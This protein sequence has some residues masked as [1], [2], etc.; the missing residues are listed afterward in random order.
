MIRMSERVVAGVAATLAALVIA[1]ARA[2]AGSCGMGNQCA[3]VD[4]VSLAPDGAGAVT[5]TCSAHD[6]DG[7]VTRVTLSATGGA[8]AGGATTVDVTP[9]ASAQSVTLTATWSGAPGATVSCAA[10]DSGGLMGVPTR[11]AGASALWAPPVNPPVIDTLAGELTDPLVGQ[12]VQLLGAAHDPGGQALTATWSSTGGSLTG[13]GADAFAARWTA[14]SSP[15]VY[16]VSLTVRNAAGAEIKRDLALTVGW[17]NP[18]GSIAGA[19]GDLMMPSRL[20]VDAAGNIH[21][22]DSRARAV[23]VLTPKGQEMRRIAVGG[24]LG[25]V[26][27]NDAG[28]VFVGELDRGRV[29]VFDAWGLPARFLG[30][31]DGELRAPLGI[32]VD[33]VGHR[34]FVADGA[35][36]HVKIFADPSGVRLA[37]LPLPDC[38]PSGIAFDPATGELFVG[39][40]K[41]GNV[42]VLDAAGTPLRTLG[43]FGS[44]AGQITRTGGVAIGRDG[45][46]YVV[47]T[48]QTRV[49]VF[50][51][52]GPFLAFVGSAGSAPG[53]LALPLDVATTGF[54]QILVAASENLRL[55]TYA[56]SGARPVACPGDSDCDGMPDG[57]EIA[58][59]LNPHDPRDAYL[60]PDNDGLTNLAELRAGTDP[61]RADTDG[62]GMLD[63]VE[64]SFGLNPLDPG[65]N[66][67]VADAGQDQI[68]DPTLVALDGRGSRDP[69]GDPL[70]YAWE[71]VSGPASVT[72]HDAAGAEPSAVLRKAGEYRFRLRVNDGR[73]WSAWAGVAI[74]V[75]DVAPL[76]DAGRHL[77]ARPHAT[78]TLDGRFSAD[79][80]GDTL[81]YAWTQ[82]VGPEVAL[83][84]ASSAL[85]TFR[86]LAPG[87]YGFD[88]AVG[89]G[90]HQSEVARV[91]VLVG[92]PG[93][94]VPVAAAPA[95]VEGM[96]GARIFLDGSESG[97]SDGD[98]LHHAWTLIEGP[99]ALLEGQAQRRAS[100]TATEPG[101][102]RVSHTVTDGVYRSLPAVTT[103]VVDHPTSHVPRAHAAAPARAATLVPVTLD[104]SGSTDADG[105]AVSCAWTQ[106]RGPRVPL[107]VDGATAGFIAVDAGTYE[108]ELAVSDGDLAGTRDRVTVV[109]DDPRGNS[110][111][112]ARARASLA[113]AVARGRSERLGAARPSASVTGLLGSAFALSAAG[114]H[115]ADPADALHFTWTQVAGPSVALS[116]PRAASPTVTPLVP[117]AYSFELYADDGKAQSPASRVDLRVVGASDGAPSKPLELPGAPHQGAALG[118]LLLAGW[119]RRR[120]GLLAAAAALLATVTTSHG[121]ATDAPHDAATLGNGCDDCHMLHN[122]PGD[123]LTKTAGNANLCMSCHNAVGVASSAPFSSVDQALPGTSG[124]SHRWDAV[125]VDPRYGVTTPTDPK[126]ASRLESGHLMCSTCHDQ[127]SQ[128]LSPADP[129]APFTAGASGRHFQRIAN[130]SNAMCVSCHAAW[131]MTSAT[132]G[133]YL[134]NTASAFNSG[135]P[136][137]TGL[138]STTGLAPGWQ[139]KRQADSAAAYT[140]I[141]SVDGPTQVTLVSSYQGTT[142]GGAWDGAKLL[143]HP[144]S[145]PLPSGDPTYFW[146]PNDLSDVGAASSAG[147]TTTLADTTK[148]WVPGA[149]V[150]QWI[151]FTDGANA[152]ERRVISANT[153]TTVTFGAMPVAV[154]SGDPYRVE[155]DQIGRLVGVATGG[156]TTTL[157][158]AAANFTGSLGMWV[159]VTGPMGHGD[160]FVARQI[161]AVN[162]ATQI[163]VSPAFPTAPTGG[164]YEVDW[165][166]NTSNNLALDNG[167]TPSFT[168][169]NVVCL[170]CHGVHFADSSSATANDVAGGGDGNLLRR[171][172]DGDACEG[173]HNLRLHNSANLGSS[174]PA[175]GM[176]F[177]C[178]TCHAP[179]LTSNIRLVSQVISTPN[180]GDRG[181]DL[182]VDTGGLQAYGLAT[183]AGTGP[184]EVCHTDTRNGTPYTTG[185][186]NVATGSA[187]VT[188][189]STCNWSGNVTAGWEIQLGGVWYKVAAVAGNTLTLATAYTGGALAG[190]TYSA[191]NPRYRNDG[192]GRGATGTEHYVSN[193]LA[194]H[195]HEDGFK[196]G[197]STGGTNCDSCHNTIWDRMRQGGLA[198]TIGG[199]TIASRHTIAN[200]P[201]PFGDTSSVTWG[202]PL[203]SSVAAG[204]RTCVTMCHGDH[205]H[206]TDTDATH[207]YNVYEDATS[208][209]SRGD[210]TGDNAQV[211]TSATRARTDFDA[212]AANGGMCL[213]CHRFPVDGTGTLPA[214]D[215]AQYAASAHNSMAT[216]PGGNWTYDQHSSPGGS[217]Q[218]NCTKCH[219]ERADTRPVDGSFPFEAVHYSQFPNLLSGAKNAAVTQGSANAAKMATFVCYNCHGNTS[220][221]AD[222]SG[223]NIQAQVAKAESASPASGHPVNKDATHNEIAEFN[224]SAFGAP[225]GSGVARHVSCTDCHDEHIAKAGGHSYKTGT[226]VFAAGSTAV[227]GTGTSWS[228]FYVGGRIKN[229]TNNIWYTIAAVPDATHV[230]LSAASAAAGTGNYTIQKTDSNASPS[231]EGAWG[232]KLSTNPAA[233]VAGTASNYTK[234]TL[235]T[236]AP[237]AGQDNLE[238]SLC[239]KCHSNYAWGGGTPAMA[240]SDAYST[241]TAAVAASGVVTGTGTTFTAVMINRYFKSNSD[242]VYRKITAVTSATSITVSPAPAAAITA[243]TYAI[244]IAE[245]DQAM[246]FNPANAGT[247][248]TS[249]TANTWDSNELAG[250][251][252]PVL[253]DCSNNLG[254]VTLTNLTTTNFAWSTTT[255]NRMTCGDCHGSDQATDPVGPHGSAAKF[256]LTGPNTAWNSTQTYSNTTNGTTTFCANCHTIGGANSRF[257]SSASGNHSSKHGSTPCMNCHVAIPHGSLR[258]GLL[259]A[260]NGGPASTNG[261]IATTACV[262][263]NSSTA[264]TCLPTD[265]PPYNQSSTGTRLQI[266]SYPTTQTAGWSSTS[267]CYCGAGTN[268]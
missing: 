201:A 264:T 214:I 171:D 193:C 67:P 226:A 22:A 5:V 234:V 236:A 103:V 181:V 260:P 131:N 235:T 63:G 233:W 202:S 118:L 70:E 139:I 206:T 37:I 142:G 197:E 219:A 55:E 149:L 168:Q 98:A 19:T 35:A 81:T 195:K 145:A 254:A 165:D 207:A 224:A 41:H 48:F 245:T 96:V 155:K 137:V 144:V 36:Q 79:A 25:G 140:I 265:N 158:D 50:S 2:E 263:G 62:D 18:G 151:M 32:A 230:T 216:S 209:A 126:M 51:R 247:W 34:V 199:A 148:A 90:A 249:G 24:R 77:A 237:A 251:F 76:A 6:P 147:T 94:H 105:D 250:S 86:P 9:T 1:P 267:F 66:R 256:I 248:K 175:W 221:G 28:E 180:S 200:A 91:H 8:F 217:F 101:V 127:H 255:R 152:A 229:N 196:P 194:C 78:V 39:D 73:A 84:G 241:G 135:S 187:T 266:R 115:D 159:R 185:T 198:T 243:G 167:G 215:K 136:V 252:H 225:L 52:Q 29:A 203:Q 253:A 106:L 164:T 7:V 13:D 111:P 47:D 113:R 123:A 108:F 205:D 80:N 138:V 220:V 130:N 218:R 74:T 189:A 104:C 143:S 156:T 186:V 68:T 44:G 244:Q 153:A 31:G 176:S 92:A 173:C 46:V 191:A 119:R 182:R 210:N 58:H 11:G 163:T 258:P 93:E 53:Q 42:R 15:G 116:D 57:W 3:V 75:R 228:S 162:G 69:N 65:D 89:D 238:A 129:T 259:T 192:S 23:R 178:R 102:Y 117:G 109:I 54:G 128:A 161:T 43:G 82:S 85:P 114:S 261:G 120:G 211:R 60:D 174:R 183:G 112:S 146:P 33:P 223:K 190:A 61:N 16:L 99:A 64:V 87:L 30:A 172:N 222:Y 49:A 154:A 10:W 40:A 184:C 26:G 20:A 95:L 204:N 124:S 27:V 121:R 17:A 83:K 208:Y 110:V 21:V 240:V 141:K 257:P 227:V 12:S 72:L 166:G 232:A 242:G 125:T 59:G 134:S 157:I 268:H 132:A 56:L 45:N 246:E 71:Q 262:N 231:L 150:G 188:C 179:H 100:L 160:R 169:G 177:T 107:D 133:S 213:S 122:S 212:A 14:P 88:L 239:F 38:A 97:D 4:A 170:S